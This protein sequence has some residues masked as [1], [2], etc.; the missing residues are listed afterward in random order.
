LLAYCRPG[1]CR[2]IGLLFGLWLLVA[3]G[4][5]DLAAPLRPFYQRLPLS[6]AEFV[7]IA[8]LLVITLPA[9]VLGAQLKQIRR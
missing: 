6:P 4:V 3:H 8:L 1:R 5:A 2:Q 9:A 7:E